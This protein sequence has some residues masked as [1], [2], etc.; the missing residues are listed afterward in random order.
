MPSQS[1][2]HADRVNRYNL[3]VNVLDELFRVPGTRWR[4]GLDAI[5]GLVPGAGDIATALV[6][7]YGLVVAFQSGA[8]ASIQLRM[9]MNLL[10]DAAFGAIPLAGD[11]FDFAFKA[12]TRN[13]RLLQR[14]LDRPHQT[15]R[16]SRLV[17]VFSIA[18]LIGSVAGALWL[19]FVAVRGIFGLLAGA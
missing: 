13:Q 3:I 8:P 18:V 15:R 5:L 11:L 1:A 4:F 9:L 10:V 6:G 14:W 12:H 19:V 7:S 2:T 16:S 17:L